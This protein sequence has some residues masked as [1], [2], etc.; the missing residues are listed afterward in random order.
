MT[1][2]LTLEFQFGAVH[3]GG[4]CVLGDLIRTGQG[5]AL[6]HVAPL[7]VVGGRIDRQSAVQPTR[8]RTGFVVP[9]AIGAVGPVVLPATLGGE[10]AGVYSTRPH[11]ARHA[12]VIELAVG[13]LVRHLG[14]RIEPSIFGG[15]GRER[16]TTVGET[17]LVAHGR[18]LEVVPSYP[19]GGFPTA[20]ECV[21]QLGEHGGLFGRIVTVLRIVG[22]VQRPRPEEGDGS[23]RICEQRA[24]VRHHIVHVV[25]TIGVVE[26]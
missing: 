6:L 10:V 7:D 18:V 5:F 9:Q 1:A 2:D 3:L 12:G 16:G 17:V 20:G 14:F 23:G 8:L 15:A 4:A 25:M 21:V 24:V 19:G 26:V 11:A 13:R 22:V